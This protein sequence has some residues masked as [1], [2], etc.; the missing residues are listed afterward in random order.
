MSLALPSFYFLPR[1]ISSIGLAAQP[2][3]WNLASAASSDCFYLS[4]ISGAALSLT[5]KL[6]VFLVGW[7]TFT[8]GTDCQNTDCSSICLS[9]AH[10]SR[11]ESN[12]F[13]LIKC[14]DLVL[15]S[16]PLGVYLRYWPYAPK[17]SSICSFVI[18]MDVFRNEFHAVHNE[19]T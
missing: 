18:I 17:V 12:V 9:R 2:L 13:D 7:G 8:E 5:F 15:I 14:P 10:R 6:F 16:S 4:L 1:T 3:A 11:L 19:S